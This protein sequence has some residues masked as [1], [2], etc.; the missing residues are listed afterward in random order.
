MK[1]NSEDQAS[2]QIEKNERPFCRFHTVSLNVLLNDGIRNYIVNHLKVCE[3]IEK[4]TTDYLIINDLTLNKGEKVN[5]KFLVS[6]EEDYYQI[7]KD[8]LKAYLK[9]LDIK[10]LF[11]NI[12]DLFEDYAYELDTEIDN[13]KLELIDIEIVK[14]EIV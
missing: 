11:N 7:Y 14:G 9:N 2:L 5:I 3:K 10:D 13:I 8:K 6:L 12:V 4:L 1:C